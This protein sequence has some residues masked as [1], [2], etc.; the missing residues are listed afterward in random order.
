MSNVGER[1][2][3]LTLLSSIAFGSWEL[4]AEVVIVQLHVVVG[5]ISD[6]SSGLKRNSDIVLANSVE[7]WAASKSA[8]FVQSFV[9]NVPRV[10]SNSLVRF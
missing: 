8:I 9:D 6:R 5:C 4:D 2:H 3:E 7:P 10:A 1:R